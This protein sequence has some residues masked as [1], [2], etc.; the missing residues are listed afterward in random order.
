MESA[1]DIYADIRRTIR[2]EVTEEHL[3]LLRNAYVTWYNCEYG[4]PG[5]DP[6]RPYGN[7]DVEYDIAEILDV[8]AEQWAINGDPDESIS[9]DAARHF[10]RL[11]A[12]T[13]VVLQIALATG[14]FATG[15][16]VRSEYGIDWEHVPEESAQG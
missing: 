13:G 12:E 1:G 6:K 4:A 15:T 16:Y 5:I 8:P 7:S 14:T 3:K 9:D 2:F 11:H 10:A